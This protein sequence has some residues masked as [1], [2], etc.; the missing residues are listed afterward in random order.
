M[1][2]ISVEDYIEDKIELSL[3]ELIAKHKELKENIEGIEADID[4]NK[5][6]LFDMSVV[7]KCKHEYLVALE[8]LIEKKNV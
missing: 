6:E 3:E 4:N 1:Q 8:E 5:P 2:M 7:L